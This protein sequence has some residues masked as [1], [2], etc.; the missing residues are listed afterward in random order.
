MDFADH[1][2]GS[3]PELDA[4]RDHAAT[5]FG[6]ERP[7]V[8][9]LTF[10]LLASNA[11]LSKIVTG[12]TR[13][14]FTYAFLNT[15]EVSVIVWGGLYL[16]L[17]FARSVSVEPLSVAD[18]LVVVF[19]IAACFLPLSPLTWPVLSVVAIYF[20][21]AST[22][23]AQTRMGWAFL[24]VTVP[25]F[26]SK[27]LFSVFSNFFL[28]IDASIVASITGTERVSNVV[29][30][31]N[32]AG[33]MQIAAPCSSMANVSL[34]MCC[35]M[36]FTQAT[37]SGW[38]P[39]NLLWCGLAC[40]AVMSINIFRISMIGYFPEHF[41]LLHGPIGSSVASWASLFVVII[42]CNYG[43]GRGQAKSV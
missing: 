1:T 37:N 42:I 31:P 25:M 10:V 32:G 6:L 3:L 35:W 8:L 36:L 21:W 27:Q 29:A 24:A 34:A 18:K 23:R 2:R 28:A 14:G 39:G 22:Q 5:F 7:Q 40:V 38:R 9:M 16:G 11:L 4:G 33:F 17:R 30:M 13:D 20:I 19:A 12:I 26:W 43:V 15:F 41:E